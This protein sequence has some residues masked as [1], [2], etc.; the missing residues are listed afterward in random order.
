MSTRPATT[1]QIDL[2]YKNNQLTPTTEKPTTTTPAAG[3]TAIR[4]FAYPVWFPPHRP[5][6]LQ[7]DK[8]AAAASPVVAARPIVEDDDEPDSDAEYPWGP[9]ARTVPFL[10]P[11]MY[12]P[13]ERKSGEADDGGS[14][15]RTPE[16]RVIPLLRPLTYKPDEE[17][18]EKGEK[19]E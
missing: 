3:T 18:R 6:R 1:N 10:L 2:H 5:Q 9:Q 16:A 4:D 8:P 19:G 14:A 7:E 17:K 13:S 11:L 12:W 15:G